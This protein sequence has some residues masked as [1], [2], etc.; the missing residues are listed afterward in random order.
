MVYGVCVME[1]VWY[2]RQRSKQAKKSHPPTTGVTLYTVKIFIVAVFVS[3]IAGLAP[4]YDKTTAR[5]SESIPTNG[6][7]ID[8]FLGSGN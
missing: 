6:G 1:V 7:L 2:N 4:G 3:V 8:I 5:Q